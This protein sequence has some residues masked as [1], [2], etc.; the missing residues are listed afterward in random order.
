MFSR[1]LYPLGDFL[2]KQVALVVAMLFALDV[3]VTLTQTEE[4]PSTPA[5][6]KSCLWKV[7][8]QRGT[9]FLL[10]SVHVLKP[11]T[12]PVSPAAEAAFQ[13][14]Q[15]VVLEV[16]LDE[17]DSLSSL[18]L[19]RSKGF[20]DRETLVDKVSPETLAL[21]IQKAEAM[22]LP[23]DQIRS[24]K[25]WLLMVTLTATKLQTLGFDPRHGIDR[26]FFDKAK[27]ASKEIISL[28]TM[29]HQLNQLDGI[30]AETQEQALLQTLE[31][32]DTI[33]EEFE[34]LLQ[35]WSQ[36]EVE[37]LEDL[38]FKGFE[39]FPSVF[40]KLISERNRNWLPKIE[41]FLDQPGTTLVVVG[42]AHLVGPEGIVKLLEEQGYPVRQL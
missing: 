19:I 38:L 12:Y 31:E 7:S 17:I 5:V 8:S 10:G 15:S 36:G 26:Y 29:E 42:A 24:L 4:T 20:L 28:E 37:V 14:A 27:L 11:D 39:D 18:Q 1:S 16:D 32:L 9:V 21:V 33:E 22:G 35:A 2:K 40:E 41:E 34:E 23:Y 3:S 13:Q 6:A 30:S 25:P